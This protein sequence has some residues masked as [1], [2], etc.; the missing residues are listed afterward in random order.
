MIIQCNIV[1]GIECDSASEEFS[2]VLVLGQMP[3]EYHLL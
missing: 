1:V 3:I 2:I